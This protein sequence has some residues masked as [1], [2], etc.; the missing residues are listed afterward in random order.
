MENQTSAGYIVP[1]GTP[2][3]EVCTKPLDSTHPLV[4]SDTLAT[5]PFSFLDPKFQNEKP[6]LPPPVHLSMPTLCKERPSTKQELLT[7]AGLETTPEGE[8][9]LVDENM[10]KQQ[11]GVVMEVAKQLVKSLA[12]GRGVVGLSLP[13]RIFEPRSTL[14]RIVDW[15]SFAPTYLT[16]AARA[17]DPLER[18]KNVISF[19]ISGLYVSASQAKP[20]NPLLGETYQGTF[21][22]GTEVYCEHTSHHPPIANFYMVNPEWKFYGRYEFEGKLN[23]NTLYIRQDGPNYVEFK[24][25]TRIVFS[26]PMVKVKGMIFGDREFHYAGVAKFLDALTGIKAIVKMS[27]A[28][29]KGFFG[30]RKHDTFDGKIYYCKTGIPVKTFKTKEEEDDD[31]L[32]YADVAK[33]ICTISGSFLENLVIDGKEYWTIDKQ[34]PNSCKPVKDPLPSDVRFREDMV[35]LKY[36]NLQ[37]AGDWKVRLEEQQRWDRKIRLDNKKEK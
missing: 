32:K 12:D 31:D 14:E 16:A 7:A 30:K 4:L 36:G 17:T 33:D 37:N 27:S 20:F 23:K 29:K 24:D 18:M 6:R 25:K 19:C 2:R 9:K 11:R 22:D 3:G 21:E 35:W 15:W 26:L 8:L 34:K 5:G 10:I 13:V 1:N 28:E